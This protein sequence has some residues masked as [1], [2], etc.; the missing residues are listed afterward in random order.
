MVVLLMELTEAA[1]DSGIKTLS[2]PESLL[3]PP[4]GFNF[5]EFRMLLTVF[6]IQNLLLQL[7]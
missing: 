2:D 6:G 5:S 4:A 1:K 3:L 7:S